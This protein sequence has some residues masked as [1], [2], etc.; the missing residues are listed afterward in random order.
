M[1]W[2]N[3]NDKFFLLVKPRKEIFAGNYYYKKKLKF[4]GKT[5]ILLYIRTIK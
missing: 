3:F 4:I 1:L 5:H 2:K